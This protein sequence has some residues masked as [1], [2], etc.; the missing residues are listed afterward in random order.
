MLLEGRTEGISFEMMRI[1]THGTPFEQATPIHY[2]LTQPHHMHNLTT[3]HHAAP[4][5]AA[6]HHAAPHL[7]T[8]HHTT[9]HHRQPSSSTSLAHLHPSSSPSHI[10]TTHTHTHAQVVCVLIPTLTRFGA[11]EGAG[12]GVGA[13]R[14]ALVKLANDVITSTTEVSAFSI[15]IHS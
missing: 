10:S 5:Y 11:T 14:Q 2:L 12:A 8:P 7:T 15:S 3:P 4:H 13:E 9:P 6:P 1:G